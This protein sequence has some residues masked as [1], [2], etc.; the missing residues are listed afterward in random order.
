[1]PDIII[2][3]EAISEYTRANYIAI[4]MQTE[5]W[6]IAHFKA[7]FESIIALNFTLCTSVQSALSNDNLENH[8]IYD[9]GQ[10]RSIQD[11]YRHQRYLWCPE[12]SC[13]EP[14]KRT[15]DVN[16]YNYQSHFHNMPALICKHT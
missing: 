15:M 11:F 1:M 5:K 13:N 4:M 14:W 3:V 10:N 9:N 7:C 2:N 12:M 6:E 8:G 16:A